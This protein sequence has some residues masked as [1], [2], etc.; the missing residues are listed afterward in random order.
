MKWIS[1]TSYVKI[2]EDNM[3]ARVYLVPTELLEESSKEAEEP[4]VLDDMVSELTEY[5]H[6]NGVWAGIIESIEEKIFREKMFHCEVIVAKGVL[7][8]DGVDGWYEYK[9]QLEHD[10]KPKINEDGSVNYWNISLIEKVEQGQVIA[11]Y[12]PAVQGNDGVNVR[13]NRLQGHRGKELAPLRGRGFG[14]KDDGITYVATMDGKIEYVNNIISISNVYEIS[15]DVDLSTGNIDFRGDVVVH[16]AVR[17][18]A[19]I[20]A[21]GNITIDGQV[22]VAQISAGKDLVLRSGMQGGDKSSVKA[23]GNIMAKFFEHTN[24]WA[25]GDIQA[26]TLLSSEVYSGGKIMLQGRRGIIIGGSVCALSGIETV[27]AGNKLE[28]PTVIVTGVDKIVLQKKA[29]LEKSL[30]ESEAQLEKLDVGLAHLEKLNIANDPRRIQLLRSKIQLTAEIKKVKMDLD[31]ANDEIRRASGSS[32]SVYKSLYPGVRLSIDN[33]IKN[34][35]YEE[36]AV[37]Y[38]NDGGE[39]VSVH[40]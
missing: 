30:R 19:T 1:E 24:V 31:A 4:E 32:I 16:G 38:K 21:T 5:L 39:L 12:Q 40:I 7:P 10:N 33:T 8:V 26:D 37:M 15:K 9:F 20:K 29:L 18:G 35:K 3:E 34:I 6:D 36:Y 13:G 11:V 17:S 28:V 25:G 27:E 14:R 23:G 2:S 22:E